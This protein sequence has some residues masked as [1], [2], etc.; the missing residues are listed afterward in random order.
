MI[1][2][3][4][5]FGRRP[6]FTVT[7]VLILCGPA[8]GYCCPWDQLPQGYALS[9]TWGDCFLLWQGSPGTR[10]LFAKNPN[11]TGPR[12]LA[13]PDFGSKTPA[14][15]WKRHGEDARTCEGCVHV[16]EAGRMAPAGVCTRCAQESAGTLSRPRYAPRPIVME[17][18]L[19]EEG[20]AIRDAAGEA[21]WDAMYTLLRARREVGAPGHAV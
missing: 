16:A 7:H 20:R 10:I 21:G 17:A 15:A 18:F 5:P 13:W 9:P 8:A 3:L 2:I 1:T 14:A 19:A 11:R 12:W 6:A 4:N